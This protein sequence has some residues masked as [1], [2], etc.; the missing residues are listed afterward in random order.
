MTAVDEQ[1]TNVDQRPERAVA[2][3]R[4][5]T[6]IEPGDGRTISFRIAPFGEIATSR[7]DSAGCRRACR[8]R[9]S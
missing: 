2:V 4:F 8:T 3:R 6:Q 5:E 7:T 1:I 9:R